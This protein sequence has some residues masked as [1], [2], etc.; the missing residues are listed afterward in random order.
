LV[1]FDDI[2]IYSST[3]EAHKKHLMIVLKTLRLHELKAKLKKCSFDQPQV[4]YLGHIISENG[5]A[6]D[7]AKIADILNWKEPHNLKTLRGFLGLTGYYRRFIKNYAAICQP[8]HQALKKEA[9][10]W[11]P[12]QHKAFNLLKQAMTTPPVLAL[13]NF[14]M[15]FTLET[16]A[17]STGLG[18]VLMQEGKPLAFFSKGLGPINSALSIYEKEG[19]AMLQALKKWRHYF[20]GSKLIIKTDQ[21]SLKYLGSQRLIEGIQHKL[22]LK[23]LE[24]DYAI[25]YKKGNRKR[26]CRCIITAV[27]RKRSTKLSSNHCCNSNLGHRNSSFL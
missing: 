26:S 16:D 12:D 3:R 25:E 11:G 6:T 24:F 17:C 8:L 22:M 13:P 4:E 9:F 5:L 18:A 21:K 19:L 1:F 15:P 23:L 27:P 2:L 14:N 7:P 10:H 20:L